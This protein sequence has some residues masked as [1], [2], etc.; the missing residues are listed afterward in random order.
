MQ[1]PVKSAMKRGYLLEKKIWILLDQLV[2]AKYSA[3]I[4]ND[5]RKLVF[6]RGLTDHIDSNYLSE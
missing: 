6:I 3:P 5:L 1:P 4:K 2:P